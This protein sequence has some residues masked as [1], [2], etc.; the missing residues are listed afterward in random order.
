L[1]GFHN[2]LHG[3]SLLSKMTK[4]GKLPFVAAESNAGWGKDCLFQIS[5]KTHSV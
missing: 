5:Y 1:G 2:F 3:K 4:T